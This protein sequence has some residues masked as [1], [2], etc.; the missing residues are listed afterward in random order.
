[1]RTVFKIGV[2]VVP[3]KV[4]KRNGPTHFIKEFD[5]VW[6]VFLKKTSSMQ[7]ITHFII[8]VKAACLEQMGGNTYLA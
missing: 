4:T 3:L 8:P 2:K 1:M 5:F 7:E 6:W